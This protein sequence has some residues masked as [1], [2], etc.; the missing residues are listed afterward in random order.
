M[1]SMCFVNTKRSLHPSFSLFYSNDIFETKKVHEAL[2]IVRTVIKDQKGV[3]FAFACI[4]VALKLF[5]WV[6]G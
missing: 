4:L 5:L 3:K 6:K 2:M 1:V